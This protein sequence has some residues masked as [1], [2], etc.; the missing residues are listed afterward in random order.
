M[1]DDDLMRLAR[2]HEGTDP[3][4]DIPQVFALTPLE[5]SAL[6]KDIRHAA[7]EEAACMLEA[8][9]DEAHEWGYERFAR[10]TKEAAM[11]V[12]VLSQTNGEQS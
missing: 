12:R 1:T 7:I 10:Y 9:S 6:A 4:D 2:K 5:L 3:S 11:K 8:E